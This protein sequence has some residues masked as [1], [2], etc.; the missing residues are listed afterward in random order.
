MP[1]IILT[2]GS[3]NFRRVTY[4]EAAAGG[5]V[6]SLNT[7]AV[8]TA[9]AKLTT[10][11]PASSPLSGAFDELHLKTNVGNAFSLSGVTFSAGGKN[12]VVKASGDVQTDLS[13]VTGNGTSVGAMT[14]LQGE[15]KLLAWAARR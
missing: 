3:K 2:T 14:P 1:D 7:G 8:T 6:L 9:A 10:N 15:V 11:T 13:P 5:L 4:L 12:Y